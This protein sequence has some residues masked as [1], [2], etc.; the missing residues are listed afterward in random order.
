VVGHERGPARRAEVDGVVATDD[1]LPVIRHPVADL[2]LPVAVPVEVIDREREAEL[3]RGGVEHA[4]P[5]GHHLFADAVAG[6][7]GDA[8]CLCHAGSIAAPAHRRK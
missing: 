5:L 2:D 1:V 6:D 8:I 3:A 7:H 4:H